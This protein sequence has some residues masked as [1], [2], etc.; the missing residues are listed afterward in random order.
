MKSLGISTQS[1]T[2]S[3]VNEII[4]LR[5]KNYAST[6]SAVA[7]F[8]VNKST[9]RSPRPLPRQMHITEDY[10]VEKDASGFQ[11]ASY[12]KITAIYAIVRSWNNPREFTIEYEDGSSRMYTS[13]NR[14]TL[15][16]TLLDLCHAVGNVKVI[17]TGEL[18]DNLRL[19]PR[20]AEENYESSFKDAFF[21]ASSIEA[22]YLTRLVKVCKAVPVDIH[23]IEE[24]CR[25]MN[26]NVPCPGITANSD[27]A[28]VKLCLT[29][30]LKNLNSLASAAL[31]DEQHDKSRTMTIMLQT[32]Y[33]IIPCVHGYKHFVD[34]KEVDTRQLLLQL[35]RIDNDF[36][37][38]WALEVLRTLCCCSFSPKNLQQEYVNKQTLLIDKTLNCLI[39]LMSARI[40][41]PDEDE[42]QKEENEVEGAP[43]EK[44]EEDPESSPATEHATPPPTPAPINPP[45]PPINENSS[46]KSKS[47]VAPNPSPISHLPSKNESKTMSTHS[48]QQAAT[49]NTADNFCPNSLV[50]VGAAGLLESIVSSKRDSSSPELVNK[51]LDILSERSGVLIHMLRSSSFLIM[52]NAAI[53]MFILLKNRT[54]VAAI[55]REAALSE[56]L[57]LKH[58]YNAIFSPSGSQR[59]ISRF[60]IATWLS[61]SEKVNPGKAL[62][63][64]MLPSG[65]TEYLK[66]A[67]ISEEHR[68]NLDDLE[69]DF[70]A[71]FGAALKNR[72]GKQASEMQLRMR[73]RIAAALKEKPFD[74]G[75]KGLSVSREDSDTGAAPAP[76]PAPQVQENYRIMFH[77]ITQDHQLP[78][79]VWN[80]QTRL[81]L[82]S[83]LEAELKEFERE[84][85]LRGTQKVA[86]NYQQFTVSYESLK[87]EL[88]VG[89]IYVR[90]F[91]DASPGFLRALE[92]PNHD[93][94]FEKLFRRVL[95]NVERNPS[96]SI[97]CSKCL[98][99]LYDICRDIIGVF[100]DMLLI[101]RMLDQA[102]NMELQ[103]SILDLMELLSLEEGNLYQLLDREFVDRILKYS[104]LA[105]LNPDNIGNVL[106][107]ATN[108]VLMLKDANDDGSSVLDIPYKQ[109]ETD[110]INNL[111]RTMWVPD[112]FSC[113]RIWF[114]AP[115]GVI[116]P[117]AK[118]QRGPFRVSEILDQMNSQLIDSTW[119]IAPSVQDDNDTERYEAVVDTGR[120]KPMTEYFQLRMQMLFPGKSVHTP[121][122]VSYKGL[123]MLYRLA[124]VHRSVNSKLIPFYPIPISKKI[125]SD[126]EHLSI[127]AQLLLSNDAKVVELSAKILHSLVEFNSQVNSKLYLT[128]LFFFACRYTGNN[129][130]PL[131]N[132]F[133][134]TH[135]QQ[136]FLDSASSVAREVSVSARSVLGM[137]VPSAV[138]NIL[139][140]YGAERF[141]T[142]F[143]G[144]FDTPE[145][146]WNAELRKH[147]VDMINQHIGDFPARL[148]QFTLARYDYCP[149]PKIHFP[150]IDKEIYVHEYYLKN[151][152]DEVKFPEWPI[153]E[154]LILLRE[155]IERWR[156]EM[157]K[158]IVDSAVADA[159]KL[160]KLEDKFQN[161]DLRKA[162][163]SLARIYHP[164]RNPNGRE[165]FEKIQV[166][167]ELLSSVEL[168]ATETDITNVVLL[169]KAQNII[170]R[171]FASDVCDQKYPAYTLLVS[172]LNVPSIDESTSSLSSNDAELL[173][174]GTMLM[175][176]TC[177]VSPLNAKEFVKAGAV[178][179]LYEIFTFSLEAI[180][181]P[182]LASIAGKILVFVMKALTAI[183]QFS[184]G[185]DA[186]IALCPKFS[187]D[188]YFLLEL[189]KK[190][191]IATENGIEVISRCAGNETLQKFFSK[192]GVIWKL[193]PMLL[194]YDGTMEITKEDYDDESQRAV[195][196]QTASNMH[197]ILAA[198][199]LGR[200]S[201][202]MF[203]DLATTP[204]EEMKKCLENLLTQPLAKLLRNR[205]PWD[206]LTALN[207]NV[208]TTTKIWNLSMRKELLEFITKIDKERSPG[209]NDNDLE[210]ASNFV[211]S[212]IKDELCIGGIYVRIFNKTGDTSDIDDPSQ[213]CRDLLQY[214]NSFLV[215]GDDQ[216]KV[217]KEHSEYSI[218]AIR[219]LV[220]AHQYIAYDITQANQGIETVFML[221]DLSADCN[222]FASSTQLM[223][224]LG[225]SPEFITATAALSSPCLWRLIRAL[226]T[227]GGNAIMNAWAAAEAIASHPEGLDAMIRCG[228]ILH[229]LGVLLGITGYS[230]TYQ[231]RLAAISLLAKFLWHPVKGGEAANMLRRFLPEPIVLLLRSKAGR[232]SL[233]VLDDVCEHPELI[234]TTEMQGEVR[235]ALV[236]LLQNSGNIEN[237]FKEIVS[238][239]PDYSVSYRQLNQEIYVGGVYI[240]L[241]LKQPTYRLS[242]PVFFLEKLVEFW[243]SS[244]NAQVPIS[245]IT[246]EQVSE[247]DSSALILGKED[248]LMLVTSCIVCVVKGEPSVL[249][250]LLSW[251]FANT[252]CEFLRR[253][254]DLGR[255][256]NPVT[257]IIRLLHIL[258]T[259]VDGVDSLASANEDIIRQLTR[260]LDHGGMLGKV[261]GNEAVP[262]PKEAVLI[263]E[264]MKKIFQC[265]DA[266]NLNYF[267]ASSISIGLPLF[268]LEHAVGA[269]QEVL[270]EIRN[271]SALR[272]YAIDAL[273]ALAKADENHSM[274]I[275]SMLDMH[276]AWSEYREQSHDL[277]ITDHE[278]TDIFLIEDA[279]DK[280][281]VGLLTDG[282]T[283]R[284]SEV[285]SPNKDFPPPPSYEEP[286]NNNYTD[287]KQTQSST[288][289]TNTQS[290]RTSMAPPQQ[291]KDRHS[292]HHN[293]S[294]ARSSLSGGAFDH[295]PSS[296]SASTAAP[297]PAPAPAPVSVPSTMTNTV[298]KI[299]RTN[300]VK[301]EH[302]IGLDL[303]KD[304][305]GG[306]VI[307]RLKEM[308]GLV[309]P[310]SLCN[311][312]ILPGD[313]I[314][315]VN[316]EKCFSFPECVQQLRSAVG[317]ITLTLE[318]DN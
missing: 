60:L 125:M 138:I 136:S 123:N 46:A 49:E 109:T 208:E 69:D 179:K 186:L 7:V 164:D 139:V 182:A 64:R 32:L 93:T 244:F 34:I 264:L 272:I 247:S 267:V 225:S 285:L 110:D 301:G 25:E 177:S 262:L 144:E 232:A 96:L 82:R 55:I 311:P 284:L 230:N 237:S 95:V 45:V 98:C 170:Y 16:A 153:G 22:W 196:N 249:D 31:A 85:R 41:S 193:I 142:V 315:E 187:E 235:T 56:G 156:A 282:T 248:F 158:G 283:R 317:K 266:R 122:V 238:I 233:Q 14:D 54:G 74:K 295:L 87:D 129:F 188:M 165:M 131:A 71:T 270:N 1:F 50:I 305:R 299:I 229:L 81:E 92:N 65:L 107:R 40:D 135:L 161:A 21:G 59:F 70:Y 157:S 239:E 169:I 173:I 302:G 134:V 213:F 100:D 245:G 313:K 197:A 111:R 176:Y 303:G 89:P 184:V 171:R 29:E 246:K 269:K 88:Q 306:I 147:V 226:C 44:D 223:S 307:H 132:L 80:E 252:L 120:W 108:N 215:K 214:V 274:S 5:K 308:P 217:S 36:V 8:D 26:A 101:V 212:C 298:P 281:F 150:A 258:V 15:L 77:V 172:V 78:D 99:R 73:K 113:P 189:D 209:S 104:S 9:R 219:T 128:G 234:W 211:F 86:W 192:S 152:C 201:G 183:S 130:L 202:S 67:S 37:N 253:A 254:I 133:K 66:H 48:R 275:Q 312:P 259:R 207:E 141:A 114:L 294:I 236:A 291:Q 155:S 115:S 154:P 289:S 23:A 119:L 290:S 102:T 314:I 316:G 304:N 106:A 296:T 33:R 194:A 206:L 83:T 51:V 112:D 293:P 220:A 35:M 263:V 181:I 117:P 222:E 221:L 231:S 286:P 30:I 178:T 160:L 216:R 198:K 166:A 256:G 11:Y 190:V 143:T 4:A 90:H 3:N 124:A 257:C 243:E 163:K 94:L 168:Q 278:K 126:P 185:Q 180:K 255:R 318:R 57:A 13:A 19:I 43:N 240:R 268:L 210:P 42:D 297:M 174:A 280:R 251:G 167:Y 309:N 159:K 146:I 288:Q 276:P 75:L 47:F 76:A 63:K 175:Y 17:V 261:I 53:L 39:D 260:T 310:A 277:F 279:S 105:H 79:L 121:A 137:L 191:P 218:E 241:F 103:H 116:P 97:L 145:V 204:N 149:I 6:G 52:E 273:K 250:H 28:Q 118:N 58:F 2:E 195:Y 200:L 300:V 68:R 127:F 10:V 20:F 162:Y 84:Q 61:G 228:S 27:S 242:N 205:R 72:D 18:S 227:K 287:T 271:P 140:N 292:L 224:L 62:L 148:R 151:L 12:Q 38:Y 199:A 24:A 265:V 91:L 203:D